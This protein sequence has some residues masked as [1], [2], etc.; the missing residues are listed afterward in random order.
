MY[1]YSQLSSALYPRVARTV[2]GRPLNNPDPASRPQGRP[3]QPSQ[4]VAV[5]TVFIICDDSA[6]RADLE[7]VVCSAGWQV[8]SFASEWAFLADATDHG[9]SCLVLDASLPAFGDPLLL[10]AHRPDL[11]MI[12]LTAQGDVRTTVRAMKAGALDVF[13]KPFRAEKLVEVMRQALDVSAAAR[14]Q[15]QEAR[16][17]Q[18]RYGS[19]S[20]RE[21][22]VMDLVVTGLLNKQVGGELGIS[23]IT[24]KAHRAKVMRKMQAGSLANLVKIAAQLQF[25][26]GPFGPGSPYNGPLDRLGRA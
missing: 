7:A 26:P 1:Q 22:Q 21:R 20:H 15:G 9:P 10:A 12:C 23:E 13:A 14:R 6:E 19:L 18:E 8:R 2:T 11:P 24:V 25:A 16:Q 5:P 3:D 17:M 4:T